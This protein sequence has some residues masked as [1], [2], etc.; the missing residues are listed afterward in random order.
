MCAIGSFQVALETVEDE[1]VGQS[2]FQCKC[3]VEGSKELMFEVMV[4]A[5]GWGQQG[6]AWFSLL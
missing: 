2:K 5:R 1:A 4:T 3:N 6:I